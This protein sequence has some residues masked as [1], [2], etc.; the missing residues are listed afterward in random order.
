MS[1]LG[2]QEN[3]PA[4]IT[5]EHI[6]TAARIYESFA[7]ILV[8]EPDDRVLRA[9]ESICSLVGSRKPVDK[10]SLLTQADV[11]L[12][13][14]YFDRFFVTT[15]L[16]YAPL[17]EQCI[18]RAYQSDGAWRFGQRAGTYSLHVAECYH[19]AGFDFKM[20]NGFEPTV[21]TLLVD[22]LAA[23]TAFMGHLLIKQSEADH[24]AAKQWDEFRRVFINEHLGQ[25]VSKAATIM[26][27]QAD[28]LYAEAVSLLAEF[29][30]LDKSTWSTL[31][32]SQ[33]MAAAC[34]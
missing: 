18:R 27:S 19:L 28:D 16:F 5:R 32:R 13:Q 34:S 14:R 30:A 11:V 6:T 12:K 8:N 7:F 22:S 1:I 20:L 33:A 17:N 9:Y 29:I 15:S 21:K 2:K 23:E 10:H 26:R 3:D 4:C 24:E 31:T 25:W